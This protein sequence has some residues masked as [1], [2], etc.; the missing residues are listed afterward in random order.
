MGDGTFYCIVCD[1]SEV[2]KG[3]ELNLVEGCKSKGGTDTLETYA[4][5]MKESDLLAKITEKKK[6]KKKYIYI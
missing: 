2:N 5:I 4:T 3:D 1:G 6:T